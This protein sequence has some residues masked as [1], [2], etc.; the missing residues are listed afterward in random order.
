MLPPAPVSTLTWSEAVPFL[1]PLAGTCTVVYASLHHGA[2]T[3]PTIIS[4]G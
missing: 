2:Q 1:L 3:S 4:L